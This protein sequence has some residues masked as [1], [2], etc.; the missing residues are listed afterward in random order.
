MW[1]QADHLTQE[2]RARLLRAWEHHRASWAA[3]WGRP[4]PGVR[5][6]ELWG[7][8]VL[9]QGTLGWADWDTGV[10]QLVAGPQ[11]NLPLAYHELTHLEVRDPGHVDPR[12][13]AEWASAQVASVASFLHLEGVP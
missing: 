2:Q 10:V 13:G 3:D 7:V 1:V 9:P 8:P 12:W 6:L 11:L 5:R 4:A